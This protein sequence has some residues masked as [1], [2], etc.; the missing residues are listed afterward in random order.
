MQ[1]LTASAEI[2]TLDQISKH[3]KLLEKDFS[4]VQT[5][6]VNGDWVITGEMKSKEVSG[7]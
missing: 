4:N 2:L 6:V 5:R 3:Q 1:L 7:G